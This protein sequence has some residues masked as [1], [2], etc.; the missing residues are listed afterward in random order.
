MGETSIFLMIYL[1]VQASL[2]LPLGMLT[3][4]PQIATEVVA[5]RLQRKAPETVAPEPLPCH[6]MVRMAVSVAPHRA[7]HAACMMRPDASDATEMPWSW[8]AAQV[9]TFAA[10]T[11]VAIFVYD[12]L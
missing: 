6:S 12:R 4:A 9:V 3:R 11:Q 2:A 10:S 7:W 8:S 5:R 1:N